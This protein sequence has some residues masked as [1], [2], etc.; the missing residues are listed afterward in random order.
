MSIAKL[1]FAAALFGSVAVAQTGELRYAV[2]VTRHGVRSPTWT[3]ERLN[4]YSAS[5]WPDFAVAPGLLTP[6]GRELIKLMGSY[7]RESLKDLAACGKVWFYADSEQRT[8]VTAEALAESI[9]PGCPAEVHALKE[10]QPDPLFEG[11]RES[12]AAPLAGRLGP[13]PDALTAAHQPAFDTLNRI[14]GKGK[15]SIFDEHT[16][17]DGANLSGPISLASTLTEDLLLEYANG[18]SGDQLG[19]GRLTSRNLLEIL[20]L[21]TAYA[22]LTRRTPAIAR[23]RGSNLLNAVAHSLEQ[24]ATGKPTAGAIGP[25][26]TTLLVISGHDT[27]ISNISGMLGLSWLLP[28]YQ[29]DDTPPGG[30]L[31]FTLWRQSSGQYAVRL[32]YLAQ[33]PDQMHDGTRLTVTNPP[34][35]ANIFIPACSTEESGYTCQW[36]KFRTAIEN[37]TA[38][39]R[40][41]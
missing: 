34:P 39:P 2:I 13:D 3:P 6:H 29:P 40:R 32:Q 15:R 1:A 28:G 21:H 20:S 25:P 27:N 41:R 22:D 23:A 26:S 36:D 37:A 35:S 11:G 12:S 31:L 19:W 7:Y 33:T 9:L 4:Q 30:A 8:R 5:P 18:M 17:I 14:L 10:G 24:A 38:P 16:V